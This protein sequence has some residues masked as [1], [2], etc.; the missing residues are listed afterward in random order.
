MTWKYEY[1]SSLG[2]GL[3]DIQTIII[4]SYRDRML[5]Y[6]GGTGPP[7]AILFSVTTASQ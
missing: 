5:H 6:S 4:V 2:D 3:N 1:R 7:Y